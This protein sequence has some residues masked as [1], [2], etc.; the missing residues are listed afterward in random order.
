MQQSNHYS[1]WCQICRQL[2]GGGEVSESETNIILPGT[3]SIGRWASFSR[4][5]VRMVCHTD[6]KK[7]G[8]E[9]C[10]A[11]GGKTIVS[12]LK[13]EGRRGKEKLKKDK[14]DE[15]GGGGLWL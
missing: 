12:W 6:W 10:G 5:C 8:Y 1:F 9:G 14:R 13:R 4:N 7:N 15:M 11:G 2:E 3:S